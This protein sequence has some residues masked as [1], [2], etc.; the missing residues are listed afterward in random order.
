VVTLD[1]R[2]P[3][4]AAIAVGGGR[5][6]GL[7]TPPALRRLAGA[8]TTRVDCRGATVLPGLID[9]HLHLFAL[10]ARAAHLD[11]AAPAIQGITDLLT[12]LRGHAARLP[13]GA[14]VRGEGLDEARLG[15]LPT[16]AELERASGGRPVRLRHRSRHASVLSGDALRLL[17]STAGVER[18]AGIPTGLVHGREEA[19]GS[20]VGPLPATVLADGLAATA[21]EL[22]ALGVTTVA[23]AT[24][25]S[26]RGL[27]PLRRVIAEQRF[28]LRVHAM[29][30]RGARP[31]PAA[32]RL[33]PGPVKIMVDEEPRGLRPRPSTLA[34]RVARAA[35]SGA[36]IAVHCVGA[37]TLVAVLAAFAAL[38][39]ALRSGRRHRLEHVAECP[40]ALVAEIAALG[41]TV[42]TNP[43]FV[44]WRGDVYR[45]ETPGA[46]RS[47]LY[48]ARTLAAAGV[49]LAGAS[50]APVVP[51]SPWTGI[52]TARS[53]RTAAGAVLGPGERLGAEAAL[54]LFTSGA[55]FALGDDRLGRLVAGGPADLI[56]V[57]PDPLRAPPD[58]LTSARVALTLVAGERV[59][60]A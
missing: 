10:A 32:G 4:A 59:W 12:A 31:W 2:R 51:A 17:G 38:P 58:E 24:P 33:R 27:G 19:L 42:V 8:R 40:P 39:P 30:P 52:A 60:P 57:E 5:V 28:P 47:W 46:A 25:R 6:L 15:R 22:A 36:Q 9:P 7:G 56:V 18:R 50:D 44:H 41:L 49:A 35:A 14:W 26:P 21:R 54:R 55:A 23:E 43:A 16:A 20:L 45:S 34:R 29:R 37:A 53:R 13:P 1:P 3:R 11:C 48:R